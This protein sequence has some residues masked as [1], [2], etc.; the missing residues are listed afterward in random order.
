MDAVL[1]LTLALSAALL[2]ILAC[3]AAYEKFILDLQE[4]DALKAAKVRRVIVTSLK[5]LVIAFVFF[6]LA[7]GWL[8]VIVLI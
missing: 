4:K 6:G 3:L 1:N 5:V 8:L 7:T 2:A